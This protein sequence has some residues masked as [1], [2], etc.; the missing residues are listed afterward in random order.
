ME[1]ERAGWIS[2][3]IFEVYNH[4]VEEVRE[5]VALVQ[6]CSRSAIIL[7]RKRD[8]VAL[9][10]L[11]SRSASSCGGRERE[12][13]ALVQLCSRSAI[14]LWRKRESWLL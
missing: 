13:V 6:L 10:Q 8:L 14:I 4:L 7:W 9:V 12:L 3:V 5:L 2:S 11:C 1:E